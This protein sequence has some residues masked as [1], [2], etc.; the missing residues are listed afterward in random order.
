MRIK[1]LLFGSIGVLAET[2]DIQRRAYNKAFKDLGLDW[3]WDTQT[4]R[5]LLQFVGG[6][7]RM[8]LLSNAVAAGLTDELIAKIHAHKTQLAGDMVQQEITAPR[9]GVKE[10]IAAA[11]AADIACAIV[12]STQRA[13][14]EAIA[15]ASGLK[16][17]D[18]SVIIGQEDVS[19]GKPDP[20]PYTVALKRLGVLP[21]EALAIEDT[22]SSV[23]SAVDAGIKTIATPGAY[24][25]EQDFRLAAA[26]LPSLLETDTQLAAPLRDA[27]HLPT[28]A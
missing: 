14:I 26:V 21:S 6:Q 12:T 3:H 1:A 17:E 20:M 16:L 13:N 22:A 7:A 27:L 11:K 23:R 28:A 5:Y 18:F 4:Y 2:S 10:A 9:P 25:A 15:A 19:A 8:R 24:A